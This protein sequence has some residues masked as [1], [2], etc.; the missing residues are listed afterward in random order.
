MEIVKLIKFSPSGKNFISALLFGPILL[1]FNTANQ[2]L[3]LSAEKSKPAELVEARSNGNGERNEDH[4]LG[5]ARKLIQSSE[6]LWT[7]RHVG[8][9]RISENF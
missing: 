3:T 1:C 6:T 5:I 9:Q 4:I 8:F 7:M 2:F